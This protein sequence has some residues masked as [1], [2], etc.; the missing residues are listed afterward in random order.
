M[1]L[2]KHFRVTLIFALIVY[3][4]LYIATGTSQLLTALA[5]TAVEISVSFDN[6]VMNASKLKE[7][8]KFWK[9]TFL[10][11]GMLVAVGFMRFYL[12]L[13]IVAT[14]G[15]V[16]L[17]DAY[18]MAVDKP[19]QFAAILLSSHAII[20]G[21]GGAFLLM[22]ALHFFVNHE[23]DDHWFKLLEIPLVWIAKVGK[24]GNLEQANGLLVLGI[25]FLYYQVNG[26]VEFFYSAIAGI[27]LFM[28]VEFLKNSLSALDEWM[29]TTRFKVLAGGFGTFIYLEVLDASFSFDGVVAAFAISTNIWAAVAGLAV[30]AMAVRCM[31][32][33]MDKTGSLETYRY[34][35]HGAFLAIL[36]LSQSMFFG[37]SHHLPEWF[38]AAASVTCIGAAFLH[39]VHVNRVEQKLATA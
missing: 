11:V 4:A 9:T 19:E 28:A 22:A 1:E 35:E 29:K 37:V 13:E 27:A 5:I 39:S 15:N 30:G 25:S 33:Y 32:I 8:N 7:M 16:S 24:L 36:V 34:L 21:A 12:P 38:I 18:N 3:T 26:N 10:W 17:A 2:I 31:T 6:A 20:A 23:K 14:L